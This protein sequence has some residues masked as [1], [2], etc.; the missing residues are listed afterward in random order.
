MRKLYFLLLFILPVSLQAQSKISASTTIWPELQ[1]STDLGEDGVLFFRNQY[2]INTDS[3][4]NDLK[5]SGILSNFERIEFSLGYEHTLSDHWRGGAIVRYAIEDF[6]KSS[7]Y[8]LFLRHNGVLKS[9][10]FNKQLLAE[11]VKQEEMDAFGRFRLSAE[12]GKRLPL[13][14]KFI[15]PSI[16]YEALIRSEF[17]K[18]DDN[19]D[20]RTIDRTQLRAG[21]TYELTEN[22]RISPYFI[23]QTEYYYVLVPPVYDEDGTLLKDGFTTKRNR[24][25]PIIGL[26]LKYT[27]GRTPETASI[28]Y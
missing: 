14:S 21:V 3:R 6:P 18:A 16:S 12:L 26:E 4:Y 5:D 22:F 2:R 7:F 8:S 24:I 23:R 1:L 17:G 13:K 9:L 25:T 20:Q 19:A 28:T 11:Y 15:T 27:I 10:Y